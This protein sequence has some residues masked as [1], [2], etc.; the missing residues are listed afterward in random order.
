MPKPTNRFQWR[1]QSVFILVAAGATLSFNDFLTFPV[2]AG[3]NGGGAFLLLYVFFLLLMGV[4]LLMGEL[5]VGRLGRND[6]VGSF[7]ILARRN[8]ASTTWKAIGFLSIVAAFLIVAT[9]SVVAG[10]SL[11]YMLML[12]LGIFSQLTVNEV[13]LRFD[14]FI[15][16]T[17]SMTLWHTLFVILL[18]TI[19]AQN[20]RAGIE[21]ISLLLVPG[22]FCL[23]AIGLVVTIFSPGFDQSVRF[24]LYTDFSALD[25]DAPLV[26]LQ[27]A[28]YTLALGTGAMI[29][30]GSYLPR[31]CSFGYAAVLVIAIDLFVSILVGL[32]INALIFSAD[33]LPDIDNQFAF[34]VF[35]VV[36][37]QLGS[38]QLFGL[39]FYLMLTLA[40]LTTSIAL[41]EGP[42]CYMQ[43]LFKID[44]IK[45]VLMLGMGIWIFG[46]G[47]IFSY[48]VWSEDGFTLALFMGDEAV[49]LVKNAG[50]KD[51]IVFFS[52]HLIQPFVALMLCI[53]VAW[54]IPRR[55]SYRELGLKGRTWFEIWNY[56]ARYV[57]PVLLLVVSLAAIGVI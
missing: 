52:S 53:F 57:T 44:R 33:I 23:L 39:L 21:R 45:A 47:V 2:L 4:P 25:S 13:S 17:E 9:F 11:S 7:E 22:M 46:W 35:P 32:S 51:V 26:A 10:W 50:F 31:S 38:G 42:I 55:V 18:V 12:G 43:R 6:P 49:R 5:L 3:Q 19:S 41:M 16:D 56:L 27:R 30:Y 8:K 15:A 36:F 54:V 37:N 20:L 40:A 28:F 14:A 24:L 29:A 34:R 1:S 48:N